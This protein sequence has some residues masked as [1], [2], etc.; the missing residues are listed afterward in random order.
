[1]LHLTYKASLFPG[2]MKIRV[3]IILSLILSLIPLQY[4]SVA[5]GWKNCALA[6]MLKFSVQRNQRMADTT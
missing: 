4:D 5:M 3:G 1:M 2:Q 6:K